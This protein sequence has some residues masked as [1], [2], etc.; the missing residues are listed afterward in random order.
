MI[1]YQ[2][3]RVLIEKLLKLVRQKYGCPYVLRVMHLIVMG[4]HV[5]LTLN[6]LL[7]RVAHTMDSVRIIALTYARGTTN[8]L[9][10]L[11]AVLGVNSR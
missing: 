5:R 3:S 6:A 7:V 11:P 10:V 4:F 9:R 2:G 1:F 8:V